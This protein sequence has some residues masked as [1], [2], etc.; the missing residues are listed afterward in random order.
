M[1]LD[2]VPGQRLWPPLF[3][4]FRSYDLLET[5]QKSVKKKFAVK[6]KIFHLVI[7]VFVIHY[8]YHIVNQFLQH[9]PREQKTWCIVA[10][11]T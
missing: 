9:N 11:M 6:E 8:M 10:G 4:L 2:T 1:A 7:V 5:L 3:S